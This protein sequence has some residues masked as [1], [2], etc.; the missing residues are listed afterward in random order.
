[1]HRHSKSPTRNRS[2]SIE[3]NEF[4]PF[5]K[6]EQQH[7]H[8]IYDGPAFKTPLQYDFMASNQ[9]M[10]HNDFRSCKLLKFN[11]TYAEEDQDQSPIAGVHLKDVLGSNNSHYFTSPLSKS[12]LQKSQP[13]TFYDYHSM[14]SPNGNPFT[15]YQGY[16]VSKDERLQNTVSTACSEQISEEDNSLMTPLQGKVQHPPRRH[17]QERKCTFTIRQLELTKTEEFQNKGNQ[18]FQYISPPAKVT[19]TIR[20]TPKALAMTAPTMKTAALEE[21]TVKKLDK[22]QCQTSKKPKCSK[23]KTSIQVPKRIL[24]SEKKQTE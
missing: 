14:K 12:S 24:K 5:K 1:M 21:N 17:C 2:L 6:N 20:T 16:Q 3:Q 22:Q 19:L 13:K 10:P 7:H 15:P 23:T 8:T 18:T 11:E 9:P 4:L